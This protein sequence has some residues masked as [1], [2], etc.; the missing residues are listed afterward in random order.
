MNDEN[1]TY[2]H[3]QQFSLS[4]YISLPPS[5]RAS[6]SLSLSV[7]V[8][9]S[10]CLPLSFFPRLSIYQSHSLPHLFSSD[11]SEGAADMHT[12]RILQRIQ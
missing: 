2:R 3:T 9:L 4:I 1:E 10:V 6:L 11:M 12:G 5:L 7:Y 8:C